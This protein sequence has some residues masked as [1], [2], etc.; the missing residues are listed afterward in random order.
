MRPLCDLRI[1]RAFH[2][3]YFFRVL[4][5]ALLCSAASAHAAPSYIL[6][7]LPIHS[8]RVLTE[9]YEPLRA[10][11]EKHLQQP[12]RIE[13]AADFRRFHERTLRGDF[14]LTITPAHFARLAQKAAGFIPLVQF[15]PDHDSLLVY[16]ADRPLRDI[17]A[18]KNQPLAVIDRLAIT[19][20]AALQHIETQGLEA[21]RD[22]QVVEHRT[23]ASSAFSLI[24]GLSAAAV[25]TSQGMLQIPEDLRRKL[26]VMKHIADIPAFFLITKPNTSKRQ[27]EYLKRILL[28]FPAESEGIDFLGHTGYNNLIPA[29]EAN[30]KRAD[31]FL[32]E[33]RKVLK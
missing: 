14:D 6:G 2:V 20:T 13:S 22:Y 4:L 7:V 27:A 15:V 10:Y 18:L 16:A 9:R 32:K 24:G 3:L 8:A 5:I 21:D 11:L 31:A 12:V 29:S 1:L 25:T 28:A 26:V 19:V 23:H 17:K 30:L 33:T